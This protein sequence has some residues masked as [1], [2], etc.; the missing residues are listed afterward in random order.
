MMQLC[1]QLINSGTISKLAAC[2]TR[3]IKTSFGSRWRESVTQILL[4]FL[5]CDV[6]MLFCVTARLF[7]RILGWTVLK[8][9]FLIVSK[10]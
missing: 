9:L 8:A 3:C 2:Y 1:G 7:S 6:L 5:V 10:F 4:I